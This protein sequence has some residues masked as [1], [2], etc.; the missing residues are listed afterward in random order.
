MTETDR[1]RQ[2][3]QGEVDTQRETEEE[4]QKNG[5]EDQHPFSTTIQ[6][7]DEREQVRSRWRQ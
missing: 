5:E 2:R 7:Q 4:H 1:Q 3:R 6:P